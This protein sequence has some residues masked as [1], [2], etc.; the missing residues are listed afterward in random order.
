MIKKIPPPNSGFPEEL[1]EGSTVYTNLAQNIIRVTEDKARLYLLEYK[2]ALKAQN[3]WMTPTGILITLIATL[4]VSDFKPFIGFEPDVW[5][6]LFI[7]FSVASLYYLVCAL[8][9]AKKVRNKSDIES[10][11]QKLKEGSK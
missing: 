7:F 5:R 3:D 6:A 1:F 4:I 10:I 2:D 8:I 11:I 9:N